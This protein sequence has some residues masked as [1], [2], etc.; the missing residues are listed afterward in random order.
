MFSVT[1]LTKVPASFSSVLS[2]VGGFK[3]IIDTNITGVTVPLKPII[4]IALVDNEQVQSLALKLME[5]LAKCSRST[6][7][8]EEALKNA[9]SLAEMLRIRRQ[10]FEENKKKALEILQ[11][12]IAM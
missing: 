6:E 12:S 2:L 11:V 1:Q 8:K 9:E 10:M 3:L 5:D 7:V 4:A